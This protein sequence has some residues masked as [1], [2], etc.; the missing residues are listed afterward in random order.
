MPPE[1][2]AGI[3]GLIGGGIASL[4][5]PWVHWFIERRRRSI[6]YKIS[7]INDVRNLLDNSSSMV[8]VKGSSLWGFINTHLSERERKVAL[9]VRTIFVQTEDGAESSQEK[10]KMAAISEMLSRLEIEWK[11]VKQHNK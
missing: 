5:S 1:V 10:F 2:V 8:E 11:L 6:E 4:I 3:F 7:L 9:P